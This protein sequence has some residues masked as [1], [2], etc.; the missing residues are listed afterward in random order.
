MGLDK[1]TII[2]TEISRTLVWVANR[3]KE[4]G[5]DDELRKFNIMVRLIIKEYRKVLGL[6]EPKK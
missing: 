6:A 1:E 5:D 3:T 2:T 4:H